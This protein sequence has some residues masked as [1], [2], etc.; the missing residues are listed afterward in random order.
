MN[1]GISRNYLKEND[2]LNIINYISHK[3]A[4]CYLLKHVDFYFLYKS[5]GLKG[6]M[7]YALLLT[8][9]KKNVIGRYRPSSGFLILLYA[10]EKFP[11]YS[12]DLIGF[13][14]IVHMY[15]LIV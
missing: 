14:I 15:L 11:N 12:V 1:S 6:L 2:D 13:S 8:N 10:L 7:N 3:M 9:F 4:V 5:V